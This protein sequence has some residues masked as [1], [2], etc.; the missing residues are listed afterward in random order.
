MGRVGDL[1]IMQLHHKRVVHVSEDVSLHLGPNTVT[2]WPE[3]KRSH[4]NLPN[5][6]SPQSPLLGE[7]SHSASQGSPAFQALSG[8]S[9]P[10]NNQLVLSS[11]ECPQPTFG[12][13]ETSRHSPCVLPS[14]LAL[15]TIRPC[16]HGAPCAPGCLIFRGSQPLT[17][18]PFSTH[19]QVPV[20]PL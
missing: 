10:W 6:A 15:P 4:S 17:L 1:T 2:H 18:D 11:L 8:C 12:L 20:H 3:V 5:S 9:H 7:D 16:S 19:Y 13:L 14:C